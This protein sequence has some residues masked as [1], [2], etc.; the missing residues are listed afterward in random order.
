MHLN[1]KIYVAGPQGL[2]GSAFVRVLM[3]DGYKNLHLKNR[4]ELHPT[5]ARSVAVFLKMKSQI[6]FYQLL[7]K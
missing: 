4:K 6:M 1:S 7:E 2:I 5:N 3:K